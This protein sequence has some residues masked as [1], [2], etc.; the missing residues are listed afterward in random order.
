MKRL[1]VLRHRPATQR[2]TS[3]PLGEAAEVVGLLECV[4]S[5]ERD[6]AFHSLGL[7]TK[8]A[9]YARVRADYDAGALLRAKT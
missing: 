5:Q 6:H 4:Q 1:D 8:G 3:S 2:P 9:S 7:R